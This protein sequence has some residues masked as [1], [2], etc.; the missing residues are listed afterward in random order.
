MAALTQAQFKKLFPQIGN[1]PVTGSLAN[2]LNVIKQPLDQY[3]LDKRIPVV[4]GMSTS[5]ALGLTG[6]QG[7]VQD[8]SKGKNITSDM[9]MFDAMGMLPMA[10][11]AM[12]LTGKASK[13]LG[14]EVLRQIETGTGII[15]KNVID[16]RQYLFIGENSQAWNKDLAKKA[17]KLEKSG[18]SPEEIWSK[19]GTVRGIDGK[20]RQEI[21]DAPAKFNTAQDLIEKANQVK[22]RNEELK[23]IVAPVRN[24]KDLF[25]K[26]LT[27][28]KRPY[29]E[30]IEKNLN[31][32][33]KNYGLQMNPY[34]GNFA[35]LV[36]EHP[37]LYKAYPDME[38][39]VINQGINKGS[40]NYGAYYP[41]PNLDADSLSV[42]KAALD[43][44]AEGNPNWGGK[45]TALHEL[46]HAIQ[47]REGFSEGGSPDFFV[48]KMF[49]EKSDLDSQINYLNKQMSEIAKAEKM[50]PVEK[51]AYDMLMKQR[52]QLVP[53]YQ[54]L[55]DPQFV[56]SEA[57]KQYNRLGGEAESRLT[58][59]R[60]NLTPDERLKY[61]PYNQGKYGLDVPYNE[62][63]VNGLL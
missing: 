36:I 50:S 40:G 44:T 61:F 20:L 17:I 57:Y 45:S 39:I 48:S 60:M 42:Y 11:P 59:E 28:A 5:D 9:R 38:R 3:A 49:N 16:P 1:E 18:L 7:L 51:S 47:Q 56:S 30:E 13:A 4:G 25:P 29:K 35:P 37:D 32:L 6:T 26:Q 14:K 2:V 52:M 54:Q 21:S 62:L 46:Q 43:R 24:Q 10:A 23:K 8:F 27:E 19:T 15:G 31:L 41:S 63:I 55:N 33:N 12:N 58:Q 34:S 53:R 22:L